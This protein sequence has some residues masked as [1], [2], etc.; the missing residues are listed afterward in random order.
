MKPRI[1]GAALIALALLLSSSLQPAAGVLSSAPVSG[2]DTSPPSAVIPV[3]PPS[4]MGPSSVAAVATGGYHA[5]AL[6]SGG[7]VR[8]WGNNG[9]GELGNG[10]GTHSVMPDGRVFVAYYF[11]MFGRFF[12][13]GSFFRWEA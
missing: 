12:I 3:M 4:S 10:S 8:C 11:N 13:A 1:L 6:T 7:G 9:D 2:D 5:C